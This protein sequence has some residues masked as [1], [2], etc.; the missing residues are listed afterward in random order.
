MNKTLVSLAVLS[1][2]ALSGCSTFGEKEPEPVTTVTN[3][4]EQTPDIPKSEA[5]FLTEMGTVKIEF[6]EE[7]AWTKV[8]ATATAPVNFNHLQGR[9][10]AFNLATMRAKRNLAEFLSNNVKSDKVTET[11]TRTTLRDI[12][13]NEGTESR[14]RKVVDDFD[15]ETYN[16]PEGNQYSSENRKRANRI[17]TSVQ[18]SISDSTQAVIKGAYVAKRQVN[19]DNNLVSVTI[20]ASKKSINAA[21]QIRSLMGGM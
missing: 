13:V 8:S 6:T 12:V 10:D 21:S 16:G 19:R 4:L 5:A 3:E 18:D 17:V 1:A 14:D 11:M 7:G 15:T 20:V 9:D 2:F